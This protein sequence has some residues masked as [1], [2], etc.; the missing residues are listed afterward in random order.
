[1]KV[2]NTHTNRLIQPQTEHAKPVEKSQHAPEGNARPDAL[3]GKDKASLSVRARLLVKARA[4]FEKTP[5][6]RTDRVD[7]LREQ[8]QTDNYIV[9]IDELAT[10]LAARFGRE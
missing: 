1:M 10:R 3:D 6:I 2:E 8:I 4:A 7:S 9:P 5:E